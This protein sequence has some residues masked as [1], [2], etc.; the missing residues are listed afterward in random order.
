MVVLQRQH[1]IPTRLVDLFGNGFL[2]A[3][4]VDAHHSALQIQ[5]RQHIRNRRD[6]VGVAVHCLAG[7]HQPRLRRVSAQQVNRA[8]LATTAAQGLTVQA[9]LLPG[10]TR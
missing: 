10:K 4:G 8:F 7:E 5:Q 3:H 1:I 9:N 6:L 2:A